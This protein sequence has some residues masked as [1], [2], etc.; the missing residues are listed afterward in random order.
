[1]FPDF[2]SAFVDRFTRGPFLHRSIL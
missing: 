2:R 1:L